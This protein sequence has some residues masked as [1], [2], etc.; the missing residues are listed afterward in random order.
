MVMEFGMSRLGRIA[1]RE[2]ARPLFINHNEWPE[3]RPYSDETAREIDQEVKRIL[4]EGLQKV[5]TLLE[6]RRPALIALAQRLMEREVLDT[7]EL[8]ATIAAAMSQPNA[9]SN[10]PSA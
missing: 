9:D 10:P 2:G 1:L 6:A 3:T 5:R 7:E 4:E 8:Q